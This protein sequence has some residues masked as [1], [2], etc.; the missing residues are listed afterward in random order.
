MTGTNVRRVSSGALMIR[1]VGRFVRR[2]FFITAFGIAMF[3]FGTV[4]G[5]DVVQWVVKS[6]VSHFM[7]QEE[8]KDDSSDL[9]GRFKW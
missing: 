1:S 3:L 2:W 9:F 5:N 6:T 4:A 8:P 7:P